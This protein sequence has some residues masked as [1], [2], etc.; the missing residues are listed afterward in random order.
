MDAKRPLCSH[1]WRVVA[2]AVVL[3]VSLTGCTSA[4]LAA[5][6][7]EEP[8]HHDVLTDRQLLK[9][10]QCESSDNYQAKSS[11]RLY[12]GAYQFSRATWND[13]ADRYYPWLSGMGPHKASPAEQDAMTRAL[14]DER[15]A[16]PWPVCGQRIGPR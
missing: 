13:V 11:N 16:S 8:L 5:F 6:L 3:L 7:A 14:W 2:A 4:Q 9:L 12:F 1:S 15:G 10:R